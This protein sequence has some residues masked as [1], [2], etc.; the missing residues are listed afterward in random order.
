MFDMKIEIQFDVISLKGFK[1]NAISPLDVSYNPREGSS[2]A[3]A[4]S[5][6]RASTFT[7][8]TTAKRRKVDENFGRSCWYVFVYMCLPFPVTK[9][10]IG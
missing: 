1:L 2:S 3:M 8:S 9:F 6:K 5:G 4:A 10:I 7:P